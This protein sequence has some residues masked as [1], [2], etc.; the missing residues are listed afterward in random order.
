[1]PIAINLSDSKLTFLLHSDACSRWTFAPEWMTHKKWSPPAIQERRQEEEYLFCG[2]PI[3]HPEHNE[4]VLS[5]DHTCAEAALGES[6]CCSC[7][8]LPIKTLRKP[9]CRVWQQWHILGCSWHWPEVVS[10]GA[11]VKQLDGQLLPQYRLPAR[12][13]ARPWCAFILPKHMDKDPPPFH[14]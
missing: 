11:A 9:H 1:M 12:H 4:C 14:G 7:Q 5:L 2:W 6:D 10:A 8:D 13:P 3:E